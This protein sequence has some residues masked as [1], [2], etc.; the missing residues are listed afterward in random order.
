MPKEV[1]KWFEEAFVH[2]GSI[3]IDCDLCGRTHFEDD[4]RAGDWSPGELAKLRKN[5]NAN[6]D[7]F[8]GH[9]HSPRWGS[10]NGKNAVVD[11]PCGKL[12]EWENFIWGHRH[13][14]AKYVANRAKA[15]A[16]DAYDD[17]A[18]AEFLKDN[19]AREDREHK[20]VKCQDCGGYFSDKAVNHHLLCT[21]CEDKRKNAAMPPGYVPLGDGPVDDPPF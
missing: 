7:M 10:I 12:K 9:G 14:I 1:S 5:Q 2:S 16:E 6:P 19:V 11:C 21:N 20:F 8:I 17:E 3:V 15:T 18:E 4:E 13:L